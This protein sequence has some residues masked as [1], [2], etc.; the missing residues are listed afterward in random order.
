MEWIMP[1][2]QYV[3][4]GWVLGLFACWCLCMAAGRKPRR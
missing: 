4:L 1:W 2:L 3:C